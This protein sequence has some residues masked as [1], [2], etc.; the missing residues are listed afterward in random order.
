MS[1]L[2]RAVSAQL[3]QDLFRLFRIW[4]YVQSSLEGCYG[5][6]A[7]VV[8]CICLAQK[9]QSVIVVGIGGSIFL[10]EPGRFAKV[11][12]L[13]RI[14]RSALLPVSA[15]GLHQFPSCDNQH[16][17][18]R[19]KGGQLVESVSLRKCS[20]RQADQQTRNETAQV[21]HIVG[22]GRS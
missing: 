7:F 15:V 14:P 20:Q 6:V 12:L 22:S 5:F 3:L 21:A 4:I 2:R 8:C 11:L 9:N 19:N 10:Q 16:Q 18:G 17:S 13:P 1:L